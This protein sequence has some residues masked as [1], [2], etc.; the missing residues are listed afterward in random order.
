MGQKKI[1]NNKED[2]LFPSSY[3]FSNCSLQSPQ[4]TFISC[5]DERT[6]KSQLGQ[7]HLNEEGF[8]AAA[9]V[10]LKEEVLWLGV[11]PFS[12]ALK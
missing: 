12:I 3:S 11:S 4:I 7:T 9:F 5:F 1:I 10:S 6:I 2:G 8:A